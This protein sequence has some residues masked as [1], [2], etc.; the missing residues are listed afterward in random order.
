MSQASIVKVEN[1]NVKILN[2]S[3]SGLHQFRVGSGSQEAIAAT[4]AGDEV[5]VTRADGKIVVCTHY[6]SQKRII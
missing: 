3:G 1:G 5:H 6:G 2:A 4:L